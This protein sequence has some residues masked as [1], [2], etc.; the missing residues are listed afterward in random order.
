VAIVHEELEPR[1]KKIIQ[2]AIE[3]V[4]AVRI[5]FFVEAVELVKLAQ[6][7]IG[8]FTPCIRCRI[9]RTL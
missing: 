2:D 1:R 7:I 3:K 6:Y 4:F 5:F 8:Y 9:N